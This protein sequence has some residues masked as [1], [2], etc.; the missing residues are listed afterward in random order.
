MD[1]TRLKKVIIVNEIALAIYYAAIIG[2]YVWCCA[3]Q[4][5]ILQIKS[6]KWKSEIDN[7]SK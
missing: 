5:F 6:F 1:D 7:I 4:K 2:I 3:L